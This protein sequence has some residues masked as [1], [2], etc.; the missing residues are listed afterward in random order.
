MSMVVL[1]LLIMKFIT[2]RLSNS[3]VWLGTMFLFSYALSSAGRR[4]EL[5][6]KQWKYDCISEISEGKGGMTGMVGGGGALVRARFLMNILR[7][8]RVELTLSF[9]PDVYIVH[10]GRWNQSFNTIIANSVV[11]Q[12]SEPVTSITSTHPH[13]LLIKHLS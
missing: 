6:K 1:G 9:V 8:F 4:S 10:H 13:I 2:E 5:L 11:E 12:H 3:V 7:C